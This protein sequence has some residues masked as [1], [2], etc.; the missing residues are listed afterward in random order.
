MQLHSERTG[1]KQQL[2][3]YK[4]KP[5]EHFDQSVTIVA[6][7]KKETD[8]LRASISIYCKQDNSQSH[9]QF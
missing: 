4:N 1:G 2:N 3:Q 5:S 6:T 9:K 8:G 7:N